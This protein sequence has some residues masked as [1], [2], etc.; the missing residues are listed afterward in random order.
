MRFEINNDEATVSISLAEKIRGKN[1]GTYV[2][3]LGKQALL[4]ENIDIKKLI[5]YVKETNI[6]SSKLFKKYGF[7]EV[8]NK[9][10]IIKY[11]YDIK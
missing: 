10:N 2:L 9:D 7:I 6:S 5:S 1:N 8:E 11:I 4:E 3:E